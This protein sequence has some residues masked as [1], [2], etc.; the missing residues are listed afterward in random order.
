MYIPYIFVVNVCYYQ[1]QDLKVQQIDQDELFDLIRSLPGKISK[2]EVQ[3]KEKLEKVGLSLSVVFMLA[4]L[5]S[6]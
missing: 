6:G 5:M 3:A 1:A 2:Y 4:V